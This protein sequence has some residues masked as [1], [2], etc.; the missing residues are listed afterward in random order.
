M[1]TSLRQ[2]EAPIYQW[3]CLALLLLYRRALER[4]NSQQLHPHQRAFLPIAIQ[5]HHYCCLLV[6]PEHHW[7]ECKQELGDETITSLCRSLLRKIET[8]ERP[9][10]KG[11]NSSFRCE[12]PQQPIYPHL[13]DLW[14]YR[15]A[16]LFDW[17]DPQ[18]I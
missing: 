5:A 9:D 10:Q 7:E 11:L 13:T 14:E 12:P 15:G 4:E 1:P 16:H 17:R 18:H 8:I 2:F 3:A 6:K